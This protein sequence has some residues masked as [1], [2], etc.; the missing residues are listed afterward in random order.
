[1]IAELSLGVPSCN[2]CCFCCCC[3]GL[4]AQ[5]VE[6]QLLFGLAYTGGMW[7]LARLSQLL[8]SKG[9][10]RLSANSFKEMERL[11]VLDPS[12]LSRPKLKPRGHCAGE[13]LPSHRTPPEISVTQHRKRPATMVGLQRGSFMILLSASQSCS[14]LITAADFKASS[15]LTCAPQGMAQDE[16]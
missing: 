3:I 6:R 16:K 1:M 2:C 15:E 11:I 12:Q 4:E 10:Q 13:P 14:K 8:P 9:Q 5:V 7:T